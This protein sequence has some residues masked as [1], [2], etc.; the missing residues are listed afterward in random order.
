MMMRFRFLT[1]GVLVAGL[2]AGGAVF[3]QGPRAGGPGGSGFGAR[4]GRAGGPAGDV[5]LPLQALNLSDAQRQQIRDVVQRRLDEG[6][7]VQEHLRAAQDAERKAVET[8]PVDDNAIRVAAQ[9]L[10]VAEADAAV[11]R[12]HVRADVFAIL[13]T[14]QQAQVKELLADRESRVDQRRERQDDRRER[15]QRRLQP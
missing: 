10:G 11:Q 7:D 14:E 5:G 15:Q 9:D 6:R 12:A 1:A 13:T 2:A 8:L 4:G 3:A